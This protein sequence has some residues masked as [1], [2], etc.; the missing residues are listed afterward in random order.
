MRLMKERTMDTFDGGVSPVVVI[1]AGPAGLT[2]AITLARHG[3]AVRVV[4]RRAEGSELPRATVLSIRTMEVL[5]AWRLADRVLAGG[6]DVEMSMLEIPSAAGAAEGSRI[7]IGYPSPHQSSIISPMSPA[8]VPQDH[9]ESVLLEHL[10]SLPGTTVERGVEAIAARQ[11]PEHVIVTLRDVSSGSRVD[12]T[13]E[14]LIA[15]DGARSSLRAA[16]GIEYVGL[17]GL[18]EGVMAEFHAPLWELMGDHRHGVYAVTDPVGAGIL[19]PAGPDDRWLFGCDLDRDLLRDASSAREELRHRIEHAAGVCGIPIRIDRFGW[20]TSA[21]QMAD[22]FNNGRVYLAGDAAHRVTPRGGT[23]LNTAIASGRDLGWKLA[24]VLL[25]WAPPS[26]LSS[27]EGERRPVVSHNVTRSADP[28]G[29]HR[30][31][32]T[33]LQVDLGGRITHAWIDAQPPE[34]DARR[35]TIDM[36]GPGLTLFLG[37]GAEASSA[38][39]AWAGSAPLTTVP[40]PALAARALG[41][42][43]S[44]AVLVRPDGLPIANWWTVN[45]SPSNVIRAIDSFTTPPQSTEPIGS[46]A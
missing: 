23:G 20:F 39:P 36:V 2:A 33:E 17:A 12:V 3:I 38:D 32:L 16:A 6:V 4:E 18:I 24:W 37:P 31:A 45:G 46:A 5:R 19:A 13:C 1:G 10:A 7:D 21:A 40:L 30:D 8:C 43:P 27:Y 35:S 28:Q 22:T 42:G 9:L 34:S 11:T 25:G 14:Y 15:A 44:G 29:T 26:F 41:I